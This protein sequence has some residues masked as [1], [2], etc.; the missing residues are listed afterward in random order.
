MKQ[1]KVHKAS[2][3]QIT[4]WWLYCR[5][6]LGDIATSHMEKDYERNKRAVARKHCTTR[7]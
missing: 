4:K 5:G 1:I 6:S 3:L 7:G 2:C